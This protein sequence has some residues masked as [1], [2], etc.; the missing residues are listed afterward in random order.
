M[1]LERIV[2]VEPAW[3]RRHA[4]PNKNYGIH[5]AE[6]RFLL[7]GPVGA[8]Q[9]LIYTNWQLK[10]V[11]EEFRNKD[12]GD[13]ILCRPMPADIGYHSFIPRY[14]GQEIIQENC[15]YLDGKPC[16]YDGSGL[17]ALR[18]FELMVKEGGEA[19]WK[20]LEGYY[21]DRLEASAEVEA[22]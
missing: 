16:Y 10:H 3:D 14:E 19:M 1:N 20:Y 13:H 12:T 15:P 21:K 11:E 5:G 7:K 6:L 4:D 9:F 2:E 22:K 18:V 8:V 17:N